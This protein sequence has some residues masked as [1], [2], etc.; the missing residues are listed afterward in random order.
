M[1]SPSPSSLRFCLQFLLLQRCNPFFH[2]HCELWKAIT[3]PPP[4]A[5]AA[6][7]PVRPTMQL[8]LRQ[9]NNLFT[10]ASQQPSRL[11]PATTVGENETWAATSRLPLRLQP[12]P[13]TSPLAVTKFISSLL[14]FN[15][16]VSSQK[17]YQLTVLNVLFPN[18]SPIRCLDCGGMLGNYRNYD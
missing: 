9:H 13:R 16:Q 5:P 7:T 14:N 6:F 18:S 3:T 2:R 11:A 12:L 15:L 1:P 10:G 17:G 4:S 8:L